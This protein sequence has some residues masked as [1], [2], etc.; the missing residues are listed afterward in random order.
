MKTSWN[1][2]TRYRK[3]LIY[4]FSP[5]GGYWLSGPKWSFWSFSTKK[6]NFS[7]ILP[8][9]LHIF[10]FFR[11]VLHLHLLFSLVFICILLRFH[12]YSFAFYFI[13]TLWTIYKTCFHIHIPLFKHSFSFF[14][15][16]LTLL[17]HFEQLKDVQ[18]H[19]QN[20]IQNMF[21]YTY[22]SFQT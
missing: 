21:S 19:I 20:H 9:I 11:F 14:F 4:F 12:L 3:F 22:T 6:I 16:F 15:T 7:K 18:N 1:L 2:S 5:M 8:Q 13:S 10:C 17:Q